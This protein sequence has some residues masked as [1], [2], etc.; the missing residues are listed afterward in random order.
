MSELVIPSLDI[1]DIRASAKKAAE[2]RSSSTEAIKLFREFENAGSRPESK[3]NAEAII[4]GWILGLPRESPLRLKLTEG[5]RRVA[6]EKRYTEME[7]KFSLAAEIYRQ[8][9]ERIKMQNPGLRV[10]IDDQ[11]FSVLRSSSSSAS[12]VGDVIQVEKLVEKIV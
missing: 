3:I 9:L 8:Q 2:S 5:E 1:A 12:R 7:E 6:Q 10:D 4:E 11:I